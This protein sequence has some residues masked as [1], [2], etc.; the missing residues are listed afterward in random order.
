MDELN[1]VEVLEERKPQQPKGSPSNSLVMTVGVRTIGLKR[2]VVENPRVV[3]QTR[4][5]NIVL[6]L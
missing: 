4:K 1:Q 5:P 2:I 6:A 3:C